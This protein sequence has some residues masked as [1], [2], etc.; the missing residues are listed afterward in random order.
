MA[1]DH[2]FP[3]AARI[4]R[5]S[6]FDRVFARPPTRMRQG[7]LRLLALP[8]RMHAA[9]LGLVVPKRVLKRAVDRNRAKRQIRESFRLARPGLPAWDIVIIVMGV[10]DV[11]QAADQLWQR[12]Q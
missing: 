11:R 5:K 12:A 2:G 1:P 10:G 4:T 9:R 8:N 7:P 6:D 3:R